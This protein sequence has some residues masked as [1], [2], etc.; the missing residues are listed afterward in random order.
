MKTPEQLRTDVE[1]ELAF[2]PAL[3]EVGIGVAVDDTIVT[4]SGH[5]RSYPEKVAAERAAKRVE[6]VHGLASELKVE[7]WP[8]SLH[9]DTDIAR[10]AVN[11]LKWNSSIP[12][13]QVH[14]TVRDGWVTLEGTLPWQFQRQAA[15]HAVAQ[16]SGVRGV[17]NQLRVQPAVEPDMVERRI[18]SAFARAASLDA[19]RIEV[20]TVNG[21]VTLRG[22]VRSWAEREDA[23]RAAWSAPGVTGVAN[24][25]TLGAP[26]LASV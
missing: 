26:A 13:D 3:N 15:E 19:N 2:E 8:D 5:V 24:Q 23:E 21:H 25:L 12:E 22:A 9:D 7:L 16:L 17:T 18:H 4:L 10:A 1:D 14:V 11:A 6:G 20:S